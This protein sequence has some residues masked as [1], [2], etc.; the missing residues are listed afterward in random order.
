[1]N[2]QFIKARYIIPKETKNVVNFAEALNKVFETTQV[3]NTL[4]D[5]LDVIK[6][7][8]ALGVFRMAE[9]A[10]AI[11]KDKQLLIENK[12]LFER[13]YSAKKNLI[14]ILKVSE[15]E[16]KLPQI[17]KLLYFY[18]FSYKEDL[19][20][21]EVQ[22][23]FEQ[24]GSMVFQKTEEEVN[25]T[26]ISFDFEHHNTV[27]EN[28]R[29]LSSYLTFTSDDVIY[30]NQFGERFKRFN[31][32]NGKVDDTIYPI[33]VPLLT[34]STYKV[35]RRIFIHTNEYV[36]FKNG[37]G[38]NISFFI[39]QII[40]Y[41]KALSLYKFKN[42]SI[43]AEIVQQKMLT[44]FFEKQSF[45]PSDEDYINVYAQTMKYKDYEEKFTYELNIFKDV[46]D[47]TSIE[48]R[49]EFFKVHFKD[50]PNNSINGSEIESRWGKQGFNEK[51][52]FPLRE[53]DTELFDPTFVSTTG[54]FLFTYTDK[55]KTPIALIL[56]EWNKLNKVSIRNSMGSYTTL[57]ALPLKKHDNP[58]TTNGF[59]SRFFTNIPTITLWMLNEELKTNDGFSTT[60]GMRI[61]DPEV[62][63][64]YGIYMGMKLATKDLNKGVSSIS[65]TDRY[66]FMYNNKKIYISVMSPK[67][68]LSRLNFGSFIESLYNGK[69]YL[70]GET[71]QEVRNLTDNPIKESELL[72]FQEVYKETEQGVVSLGKKSV[73]L[74]TLHYVHETDTTFDELEDSNKDATFTIGVEAIQ[75]MFLEG[76]KE[77]AELFIKTDEK[78]LEIENAMLKKHPIHELYGKHGK[79]TDLYK[80]KGLGF[81]ST[82]VGNSG[83]AYDE[84]HLHLV[85]KDIP[86][87]LNVLKSFYK[88]E[89]NAYENIKQKIEKRISFTLPTD[90]LVRNPSI[91][92]G[93]FIPGRTKLF[94]ADDRFNV[95]ILMVNPSAWARQGGDFD[96]D[97]G[98]IIF[99]KP[100]LFIPLN[101]VYTLDS[102]EIKNIDTFDIPEYT[103]L[104]EFV[105]I[106]AK[107][108]GKPTLTT[109]AIL[110]AKTQDKL[111]EAAKLDVVVS[112]IGKQ[113]VGVAK[114]VSMRMLA[115]ITA[116][117]N[118]NKVYPNVAKR[119][120]ELA[121]E[122]NE[123]LVQKTIDISKWADNIKSV[124]ET[125]MLASTKSMVV[126]KEIKNR[127]F[128]NA[129]DKMLA[130][131]YYDSKAKRFMR[132]NDRDIEKHL[133][134][135]IEIIKP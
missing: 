114:S 123:L 116:Y 59:K 70:N 95:S 72:D 77:L 121:N 76:S 108:K 88:Q 39:K 30:K 12:E 115:F 122:I 37:K 103:T 7:L 33:Y 93:N 125:V 67:D 73:S 14:K 41:F 40:N 43:A 74:W 9:H 3:I 63:K 90:I 20:K 18:R 28:T 89:P 78:R 81:N 68:M 134:E 130:V 4:D 29:T 61:I 97:Q 79:V 56:S 51:I 46:T 129:I 111:V 10:S 69:K 109:E 24:R 55:A 106:Y 1:M 112:F 19:T 54:E 65:N 44:I 85:E 8:N 13:L 31:F 127:L 17:N 52:Q 48:A 91:D 94:Y 126:A 133:L 15:S 21:E 71:K 128:V 131:C 58:L 57:K 101:K 64:A 23:V 102:Y 53:V 84:K 38:I 83:L 49:S 32:K 96:G 107:L 124:I 2:N 132:S 117:M 45:L 120:I 135:I 104:K 113:S 118:E 25:E 16:F 62:A 35:N 6:E 99:L 27:S 110:T 36:S 42:I 34:N 92:R 66:Y 26:K 5:I 60:E 87:L 82:V 22:E 50:Y 86:N 105:D 119:L 47:L 100:E 98:Y 80:F 75:R 11:V